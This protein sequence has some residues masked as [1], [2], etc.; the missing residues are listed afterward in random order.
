MTQRCRPAARHPKHA[1]LTLTLTLTPRCC[2]PRLRAHPLCL[3]L[4][5]LCAGKSNGQAFVLLPKD[6]A[7]RAQ[8]DLNN[9][10]MGKRFIE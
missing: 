9:K 1:T 6:D 10:Y 7:A 5:L 8:S 3:P 2:F 4:L